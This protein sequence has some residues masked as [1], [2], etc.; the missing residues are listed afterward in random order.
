MASLATLDEIRQT[1][2]QPPAEPRSSYDFA[3]SM[4]FPDGKRQGENWDPATEPLQMVWAREV[5]NPHWQLMVDVEPSQRGKSLKGIALPLL[6]STTELLQDVAFVMPNLEKLQQAWHGKLLGFLTGCGYGGWLPKVGPGARGGKPGILTLRDPDRGNRGGRIYF[7]ATGGGGK[8]TSVASVTTQ[9]VVLDEADDLESVAQ[10]SLVF[11]RVRSFGEDYRIYAVSTVNERKNRDDHPILLLYE[12]TTHSTLWYACPHCQRFQPMVWE[13]VK[14]DDLDCGYQCAHCPAVWNERDRHLALDTF[15]LVHDGQTID[16][17]GILTGPAP[18][19]RRFGLLGWD[20]EYHMASLPQIVAEYRGARQAL[21]DRSDHGPMR[22]FYQKVLC[23]KYTGDIEEMEAQEELTWQMLL[24]RSQK[25]AW[26]PTI[27]STDKSHKDVGH[28]YSRHVA[29]MPS[30]AAFCVGAVDVQ[31]TRLYL[32]L[33]GA[34]NDGTTY[35]AAWS[36]EMARGDHMPW[37]NAELFALLDRA[38]ML[39]RRWAGE[40]PLVSI[41]LDVG[42]FTEPLMA[43]LRGKRG[44]EWKATKGRNAAMKDEPGDV[45][46]LINLR[47]GLY[48]L[49]VDNLR[50]FVLANYRRPN[51]TPGACHI[52]HGLTTQSTDIAY[53]KHMVAEMMVINKKTGR[54]QL[55]QGPGRWDWQDTRRIAEAMIRWHLRHM[56]PPKRRTVKFG[57]VGKALGNSE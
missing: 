17:N 51:G 36:Y 18:T 11:R 42:D 1:R 14:F 35:D 9:T 23:R 30:E 52:P 4:K 43:W 13:Q 26:G 32:L 16:E 34:A 38:E 29:D 55:R 28:V 7:M 50:E 54:L 10:L 48:H 6:R 19:T 20:A 21:E 39:F 2:W 57:I 49:N 56:N 46:G 12:S 37:C 40:C 5:D 3:R 24:R 25:C 8:E 15:R 45:E 22:Q 27:R 44:S 33:V 47:D 41:G 53:L 31:S